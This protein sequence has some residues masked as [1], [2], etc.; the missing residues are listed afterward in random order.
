MITVRPHNFFCVKLTI[1]LQIGPC[2]LDLQE[3]WSFMVMVISGK[4][5]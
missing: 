5:R 4:K 3:L 2:D 1:Y